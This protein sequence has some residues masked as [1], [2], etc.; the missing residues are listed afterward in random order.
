MPDREQTRRDAELAKA[1]AAGFRT[2]ALVPGGN[3][4]T[5]W[6]I[7]RAEA[8][9]VIAELEQAERERDSLTEELRLRAESQIPVIPRGA[10]LLMDEMSA[11]NERLEA[12]LAKVQEQ[13]TALVEALREIRDARGTRQQFR[14]IIAA[15]ALAA[16]EEPDRLM[17]DDAA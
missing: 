3:P 9:A 2:W 4:D 15:K 7:T 12:R 11:A 1:R 10:K 6:L 16:F 5:G 8:A 14:A 13:N 17:R